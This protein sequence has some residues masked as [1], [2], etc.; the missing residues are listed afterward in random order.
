M[1]ANA[2]N[3]AD[4][5]KMMCWALGYGG[6]SPGEGGEG[7]VTQVLDTYSFY[8]LVL[9]YVVFFHF[10]LHFSWHLG[11]IVL[12][13]KF[14][15]FKFHDLMFWSPTQSHSSSLGK[16]YLCLSPALWPCWWAL[17]QISH[18]VVSDTYLSCQQIPCQGSLSFHFQLLK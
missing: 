1:R 15:Y 18:S 10:L 8:T 2:Q 7:G 14:G 3:K 12:A 5:E 13:L 9:E 11:W 17:E 6:K 16:L 4:E